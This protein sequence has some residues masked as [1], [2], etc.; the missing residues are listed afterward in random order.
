MLA[1]A[2][3]SRG[4]DPTAVGGA[5]AALQMPSGVAASQLPAPDSRGAQLTAR[6]C[7]QCHGIPSPANHSASDWVP[8]MRRMMLRM[9]RSAS[10]SQMMGRGMMGRNMPMGMMGAA[11]PTPPEERDILAYLQNHALKSIP[12][13]ELPES[14]GSAATLYK[15]TCSRCHALP[16]P[17]VYTPGQW[18]AVVSRMRQYMQPSGVPGISDE[19]AQTIIK[20][21]QRASGG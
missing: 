7:S 12:E 21:L 14:S 17:A 10:M 13:E 3:C 4:P 1:L 15:R 6:Y 16:N 8:I 18:P 9:E 2:A 11:V 20:Y 19:Q 5:E